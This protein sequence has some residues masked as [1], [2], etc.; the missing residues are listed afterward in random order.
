MRPRALYKRLGDQEFL[1]FF[2]KRISWTRHL[3]SDPPAL[4]I[5]CENLPA[6]STWLA[7]ISALVMSS[8]LVAGAQVGGKPAT[9]NPTPGTAQPQPPNLQDRITLTGCLRPA[10]KNDTPAASEPQDNNTPTDARFVL[11]NAERSSKVPPDTGSSAI[12]A[13]AAG[14][15]YRLEGLDSQFSPF[16]NARVEISGEIR[17]PASQSAGTANTPILLVEFVRRM[18]STCE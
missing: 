13:A 17:P 11:V 18:A 4:L 7:G 14:R 16:V 12:A 10:P 9:G 3:L 2:K 15:T 1:G 5:S 8:T 6:R